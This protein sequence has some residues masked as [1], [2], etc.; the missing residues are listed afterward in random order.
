[1]PVI[2]SVVNFECLTA[3]AA[4]QNNTFF[5]HAQGVM[6]IAWYGDVHFKKWA[7]IEFLLAEKKSVTNIHKRLKMCSVSVLLIKAV[8]VVGL[9][10]LH[11][12]AKAKQSS[13]MCVAV[14][15]QQQHL[16]RFCFNMLVPH[17]QTINSDLYSR[18]LETFHKCFRRV[19][20]H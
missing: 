20:P 12:L 5:V 6:K 18:T 2:F 7:V 4:L 19:Q 8:L 15:G 13:V 14:A 17:G 9:H 3:L 11:V 1:M 10:E 16:L